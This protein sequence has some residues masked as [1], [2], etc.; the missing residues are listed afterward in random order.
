M[1]R[2]LIRVDQ[3]MEME[4]GVLQTWLDENPNIEINGMSSSI[5]GRWIDVVIIYK[6]KPQS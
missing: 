1:K 3:V 4:E 6:Q 2:V 5:I